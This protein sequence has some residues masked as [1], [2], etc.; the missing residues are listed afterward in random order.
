M[1]SL[2]KVTSGLKTE[3]GG[4]IR[5]VK[6]SILRRNTIRKYRTLA[7]QNSIEDSGFIASGFSLLPAIGKENLEG[8]ND[9]YIHLTE[10]SHNH[11]VDKSAYS[12]L[13]MGESMPLDSAAYK[14]ALD[15]DVLAHIAGYMGQAP[16]IHGLRFI[17]SSPLEHNVDSDRLV[18]N[19]D[20][21]WHKDKYD[22]Y[23]VRLFV[24]LKDV[25]S[26]NGP[27]QFINRQESK[28]IPSAVYR[29]F[30]DEELE[31]KGMMKDVNTVM[32]SAGNRFLCDVRAN[33]HCG[34]RCVTNTRL[35]FTVIYTTCNPW[36]QSS[37]PKVN[38]ESASKLYKHPLQLAALGL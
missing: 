13:Y 11:S 16:I 20:Q 26:Q 4:R 33:V 8:L 17:Q 38:S 27:F 6:G 25:N 18:W 3:F 21:I 37:L 23:S 12:G 30:T 2:S 19:R 9:Q 35:A 7:E 10:S 28:S 31:A 36:M 24:Y 34:S 29:R 22:H 5:K 15:V 32:G 14:V 1:M